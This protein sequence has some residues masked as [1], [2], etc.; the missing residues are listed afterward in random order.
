MGAFIVMPFAEGTF[1][2]ISLFAF[3]IVIG[4]VVDDAIVTGENI[5][6]KMREGMEPLQASIRGTKE[7]TVPVTFGI[8]TTV[9]AFIP[10][11]YLDGTRFA[12]IASQL[13]LIVIPVLLMSLIESK[14]VLPAHMSHVKTRKQDDSMSWF[15]RTQQSISRGLENFVIRFY[16][17]FLIKCL[18][19]KTITLATL[20]A[21]SAITIAALSTGHIHVRPTP[22]VESDTLR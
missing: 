13:P 10:L 4:I 21:A 1:N 6:R 7:I 9:A 22:K 2:V 11:N 12:R 14:L 8:L 3:I 5:Y 20:L 15:G 16:K 17:P 19:N 18:N